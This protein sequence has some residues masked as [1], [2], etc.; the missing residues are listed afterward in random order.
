MTVRINKPAINLREKLAEL[1]KPSGIVGE[2]V[3]RSDTAEDAREALNLEEHLFENFESTG[4]Q[5]NATST[6][7]TV[8]DTGVDVTG[9]VTA[10]GLMVSN[11]ASIATI[12]ESTTT[13]VGFDLKDSASFTRFT[14]SNGTFKI[15][16]N[17]DGTGG[18]SDIVLAQSGVERLRIEDNGDV[19][20]YEDTGTTAKMVWDASAESLGI[21]TNSPSGKIHLNGTGESDTKLQMSSGTGLSSI[22]GRYGNLVISADENNAVIG[23]VMAFR[24]DNSEAMRIDSSGNLL[25]GTTT[26]TAKVSVAGSIQLDRALYRLRTTSP[27]IGADSSGSVSFSV[28]TINNANRGVFEISIFGFRNGGLDQSGAVMHLYMMGNPDGIEQP[29]VIS[30][31]RI[32]VGSATLSSGV[33][34][35]NFT[36]N[37]SFSLVGIKASLRQIC[38]G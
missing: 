4:I 35:I 36:N 37:G 19:L 17:D 24:M 34:T 14:N 25:V 12:I 16:S 29:V 21:G 15:D 5:D 38:E 13:T 3:L 31:K 8:S 9:T 11:S 10:D 7:V 6:K 28:G 18:T 2:Q 20:F 26:G 27:T 22:D 30:E 1:D 32:T 33:L 23:S